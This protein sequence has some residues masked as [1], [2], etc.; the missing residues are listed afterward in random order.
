MNKSLLIPLTSDLLKLK[1]FMEDSLKELRVVKKEVSV[2]T[3]VFSQFMRFVLI[4]FLIFNKRR[5]AEPGNLEVTN[6]LEPPN[7]KMQSTEE[8]FKKLNGIEKELAKSYLVLIIR[9]KRNQVP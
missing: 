8:S 3:K 7:W 4:R 1:K 5:S 2:P 6:F 9:G